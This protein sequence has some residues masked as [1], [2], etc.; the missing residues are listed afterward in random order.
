MLAGLINE[1][2]EIPARLPLTRLTIQVLG[3]I[4]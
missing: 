1:P 2:V 3:Q 4:W